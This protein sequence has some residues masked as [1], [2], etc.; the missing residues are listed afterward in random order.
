LIDRKLE[1][2]RITSEI[3]DNTVS[4]IVTSSAPGEK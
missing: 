1:S 3:G 4:S 2:V